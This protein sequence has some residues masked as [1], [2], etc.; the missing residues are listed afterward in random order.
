MAPLAGLEAEEL[1]VGPLVSWFQE[2]VDTAAF[3]FPRV[4]FTAFAGIRSSNCFPIVGKPEENFWPNVP[5]ARYMRR[6][7]DPKASRF[8]VQAE[9]VVEYADVVMAVAALVVKAALLIPKVV[10]VHPALPEV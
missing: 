10:P 8:V 1:K 5:D 6:S 7:G 3:R 4:S 2:I 9:K